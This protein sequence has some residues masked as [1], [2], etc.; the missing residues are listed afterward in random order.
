MVEGNV[1]TTSLD[2]VEDPSHMR[3]TP[4]GVRKK[5]WDPGLGRKILFLTC[6]DM[7]VM[8]SYDSEHACHKCE[9]SH[10]HDFWHLPV[11]H[12]KLEKKKATDCEINIQKCTTFENTHFSLPQNKVVSCSMRLNLFCVSTAVHFLYLRSCT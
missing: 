8:T 1:E 10:E 6:C 4:L 5:G 3:L 9:C 11:L 12:M 2:Q 7:Y